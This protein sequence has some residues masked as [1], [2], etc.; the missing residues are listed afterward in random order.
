MLS[1]HV[2]DP[3]NSAVCV[4]G[5]DWFLNSPVIGR[6]VCSAARDCCTYNGF[7]TVVIRHKRARGFGGKTREDY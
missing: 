1:V 7:E 4:P 2:L 6:L 3:I 5:C